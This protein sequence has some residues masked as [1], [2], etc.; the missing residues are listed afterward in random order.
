MTEQVAQTIAKLERYMATVDDALAIPREAGQF[1]HALVLATG[2]T[3]AVEIGTSYGYSGLWIASA[4]AEVGGSLITID[5]DPRK[6]AAARENF[7]EA[8]L[9]AGI[10]VRTG[11]AGDVLPSIDGPI[12]FVLNDADKENCLR[13]V[14]LLAD[15]LSGRAVV[16]TDNITTHAAEL[17]TF[18]ADMRRRDDFHTVSVPIGNGM[19][20]SV[21]TRGVAG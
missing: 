11:S 7:I 12:D 21:K 14:E 3:R 16:L 8:G 2:A 6:S 1:V 9:A 20:L 15:R 13:Y 10:D 4:L 18:L 17:A 5:H 19:E